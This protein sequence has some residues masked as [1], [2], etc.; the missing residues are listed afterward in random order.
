MR[1]TSTFKPEV[2][3]II[4]NQQPGF[5]RKKPMKSSFAYVHKQNSK[6]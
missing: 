1:T 6:K 2:H 5:T 4:F 3:E